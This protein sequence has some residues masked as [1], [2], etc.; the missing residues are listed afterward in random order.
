MINTEKEII[1]NKKTE[2]LSGEK[3]EFKVTPNALKRILEIKSKVGNLTKHLRIKVLGGGC[4]GFQYNFNLEEEINDDDLKIEENG[5][6]IVVIDSVS[7]EFLSGC[8]IDFVQN[9]GGTYFKIDNPNATANCG[10]GNS[11]AV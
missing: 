3:S 4:S 5:K 11:F 10:C 6:I 2:I 8:S 9:L 7:L 1:N